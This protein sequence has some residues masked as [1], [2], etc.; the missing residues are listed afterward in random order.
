[1]AS[2]NSITYVF[3]LNSK[4]SHAI[5]GLSLTNENYKEALDLLKH[6]YGN[7][8]LIVSAYMSTL[9]K[10]A[11]VQ[12]DDLHALRK[13]CDDVES[14]V[15]SLRNLGTDSKSYG[16]FL[17]TLIIE[18]LPQDIINYKQKNRNKHLGSH[19]S[20]QFDQSGIAG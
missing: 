2:R 8:N 7:S 1:M 18:K 10:F 11:R 15:R 12:G 3:F 20:S 16:S 17:S 6:R 9:V 5:S 19:E 4:A 14:N 13:F